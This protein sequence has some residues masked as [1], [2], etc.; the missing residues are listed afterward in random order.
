[1]PVKMRKLPSGR[2]R[3]STPGGVKAKSTTPRKAKALGNLLR[4]VEHG[5]RPT[6]KKRRKR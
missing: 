6:G 4:G 2:V 1:M 3:V 5:W